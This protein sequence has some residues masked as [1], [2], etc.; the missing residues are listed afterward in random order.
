MRAPTMTIR[1]TLL[2]SGLTITLIS[3][4]Q[5]KPPHTRYDPLTGTDV[6]GD[7]RLDTCGWL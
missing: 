2:R 7:K 6:L 4:A 3:I 1:G 5:G